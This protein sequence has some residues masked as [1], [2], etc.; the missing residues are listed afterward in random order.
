[1]LNS[2]DL[3]SSASVKLKRASNKGQ[4]VTTACDGAVVNSKKPLLPKR[5]G[6][7]VRG[8]GDT[9]L[10]GVWHYCR[11]CRR[12][13]S[14]H[15]RNHTWNINSAL[16]QLTGERMQSNI[17]TP[18]SF[19]FIS[20]SSHISTIQTISPVLEVIAF[21]FDY[22]FVVLILSIIIFFFYLLCHRTQKCCATVI[23]HFVRQWKWKS[24]NSASVETNL[25]MK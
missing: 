11:L 18:N 4:K 7:W 5:D 25:T 14:V 2:S 1:M 23:R 19:F 9:G 6:A 17:S 21:Y 24:L 22:F 15:H 12:R 13:G 8:G 20:S 3:H 10:A 16:K